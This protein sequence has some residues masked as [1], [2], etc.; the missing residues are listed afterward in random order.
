MARIFVLPV[1]PRFQVEDSYQASQISLHNKMSEVVL[2]SHLAIQMGILFQGAT[3]CNLVSHLFPWNCVRCPGLNTLLDGHAFSLIVI[4]VI[5]GFLNKWN[6]AFSL[7]GHVTHSKIV[8]CIKRDGTTFDVCRKYKRICQ[9]L[10]L[11]WRNSSHVADHNN[12][13]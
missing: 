10:M 12:L 1:L 2:V 11:E 4:Y 7:Y 9:L 13:R 8:V 5:N 6:Q 3:N